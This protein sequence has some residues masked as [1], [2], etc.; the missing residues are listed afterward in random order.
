M[1]VGSRA[2]PR[3]RFVLS[4]RQRLILGAVVSGYVRDGKPVGSKLIAAGPGSDWSASTIRSELA[5]LEDGGFLSHPHTSAGRVPTDAGY[6]F[7][8]EQLLATKELA[9]AA[10]GD[11]RL[12]AMRREVEDAIRETTAELSR[13]TDLVAMV[14]A[15]PLSTATI[16]RVE[17]LLLA[18]RRVMVVVIA[19]N[20][21][22]SKRV[23]SFPSDVDTGVVAWASS[24][25]N[26]RLVGLG[27]GA[28]M[29]GSRI[30]DPELSD[31]ER[32]FLGEI[33]SAFTN[34]E[35]S[36]GR[37]PCTWTAPRTCSPSSAPPTSPTRR[38]RWRPWSA[39]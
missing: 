18:P 12:S 8:V 14:S 10:Q 28:R 23:F 2:D 19:S 39:E 27:L 34:L 35:E 29:A 17:V 9:P 32:D 5:S 7:Y 6:R 25:L 22:V 16:H 1:A 3:I 11:M 31:V 4:E 30:A 20:G 37:R 15:P 38:R 21:G 36:A 26:E 33:S 24:Y 13:V